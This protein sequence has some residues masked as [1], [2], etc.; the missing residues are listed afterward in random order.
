MLA[1][2][3]SGPAGVVVDATNVYWTASSGGNVYKVPLDGGNSTILANAQSSPFNIAVDAT[4]VY[5]TNTG[6][7]IMKVPIAGGAATVLA[8]G[9]PTP[10]G[11]AIDADYVYWVNGYFGSTNATVMKVPIAGGVPITIVNGQTRPTGIAVDATSVYWTNG[12]GN[13]ADSLQ[14]CPLGGCPGNITTTLASGQQILGLSNLILIAVDSTHVYWPNG[15]E[16]TI[17]RVPINGGVPKTM[18][19]GQQNPNAIVHDANAIYWTT[20]QGGNIMMLAK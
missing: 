13:G 3:L 12:V 11:I 14:K 19:T 8:S 2:N 4:N 16:G 1:S 18:A 20:S 17:K 15:A 9:Q 10:L 5:W 7:T 6:G